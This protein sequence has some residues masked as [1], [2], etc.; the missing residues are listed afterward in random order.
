M[1]FLQGLLGGGQMSLM[2][3]IVFVLVTWFSGSYIKAIQPYRPIIIVAGAVIFFIVLLIQK[4]MAKKSAA[5]IED[6]LQAQAQ[7]QMDTARPDKKPQ[8]QALQKQLSE[9]IASLKTSKMGAGALYSLP[10]YIIIGP[11]GSGKST[12]LQ[13]SGLNFPYMSQ[14]RK[15]IRGVGGTRNCDWWFTD[16]GILL[17]TAGRYTTELEDRDEW[18]AFLDLLKKCR[19]RKPINGA[20]VC[21]SV[22][23]L[24][25][26]SDEEREAHV[27]NIRDRIDELTKRLEQIFPVY[28][29]FTK[30]DL[31]NGFTDFFE[32]Y[33]K[34]ERS[35]V[36]GFTLPYSGKVESYQA[37]FDEEV[38][39]LYAQL[40]AQRV[41]SLAAERP[42]DKK[43][44]IFG[45]PLQFAMAHKKLAD[46]VGELFR[47]NPFQESSILRGI[48]FTSGTQEG[49]PIDQLVAAMGGA[50]GLQE[51]AAGLLSQAVDRKSYFINTLFT[52][53]IFGDQN[54]ARSATR[55]ANRR[56]ILR[57]GMAAASVLAL[58][59]FTISLIIAFFGN[60]GLMKS[61]GATAKKLQDTSKSSGDLAGNLQ[62]LED[63]RVRIDELDR[64]TTGGEL[65]MSLRWGLYRGEDVYLGQDGKSGIRK[66]YIDAIH[67]MF[68][69]PL[70]A[71][72]V[73]EIDRLILNTNKID[74]EFETLF[75]LLQVYQ[76]MGGKSETERELVDSVLRDNDRWLASLGPAA[77]ALP[78]PSKKIAWDQ[79]SFYADQLAKGMKW[80]DIKLPLID[81]DPNLVRRG[82][83]NLKGGVWITETFRNLITL[84]GQRY[85]PVTVETLLGATPGK[86]LFECE[87]QYH[88]PGAYTKTALNEYVENAIREKSRNLSE[89]FKKLKEDKSPESL[90]T[91]LME[92]YK[93]Q[94]RYRWEQFV[95]NI[96][97]RDFQDL[98]DA[99][100]KLKKLTTFNPTKD[101]SSPYQKLFRE[102]WLARGLWPEDK[103]TDDRV[104][105]N[106]ALKALE[107][108]TINVDRIYRTRLPGDRFLSMEAGELRALSIVLDTCKT[109]F[110]SATKQADRNLADSASRVLGRSLFSTLEACATEAQA[111]SEAYWKKNVYEPYAAKLAGKYPLAA[112]PEEIPMRTFSEFFN[113]KSGSFWKATEKLNRLKDGFKFEGKELVRFSN[114]YKEGVKRAQVF[115]DVLYPSATSEVIEQPLVLQ[116]GLRSAVAE[117]ILLIGSK[118]LSSRDDPKMRADLIWSEAAPKGVKLEIQHDVRGGE[119]LRA[120]IDTYSEQDWGLLRLFADS[121]P[122][123][124]QKY[125]CTWKFMVTVS[126]E[127][128]PRL[129]DCTV[130]VP[131]KETPFDPKFFAEFKLP[132]RMG[133]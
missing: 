3:L 93:K 99:S 11:P 109:K 94:Y 98:K 116:F 57:A 62:A 86:E 127:K 91:E 111:E 12:A 76:M 101:D 108:L 84:T 72:M 77:A 105:V 133:Q 2:G 65:P 97:L 15:G 34:T 125:T 35:Q 70:G 29:V 64:Y 118:R 119:G 38:R 115:R 120:S 107:E 10:W 92:L 80:P 96:K 19:K 95:T 130:E 9:A 39:K 14:G 129:A 69:K 53:I 58:V 126:G 1:Q 124:A 52:K 73:A 60:L 83:E 23:D 48:Y 36:W 30:C 55:V 26:C 114:E 22:A 102:I 17:D 5:A 25:Q 74:K 122:A 82:I 20:I 75:N 113:P 79:L 100:D 24:V 8:V 6:R 46:F 31:L 63:L 40:S 104:W 71:A 117:V 37:V 87:D 44:R 131:H 78:E 89:K 4:K 132:E 68:L 128:V 51:D 50:F 43:R 7:E 61:V 67:N 110:E 45:F 27:K 103:P 33:G 47:P 13:E 49:T 16:Q 21:V 56:R 28:L 88:V 54:L 41:T 123:E 32:D 81:V 112:A 59:G 18:L 42:M 66:V 85:P 106:D 90:V 121:V